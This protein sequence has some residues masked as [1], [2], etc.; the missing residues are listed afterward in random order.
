MKTVSECTDII[1][2]LNGDAY[3]EVWD[4]WCEADECHDDEEA[5][6]MREDCSL[7][8]QEV[9]RDL[10]ANLDED[11]QQ[12]IYHYCRVDGD[13]KDTFYTYYGASNSEDE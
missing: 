3:D 5:E 10:F 13:F 9:F 1:E 7:A 6:Y 12:A 11:T 8:Q 2:S 4:M